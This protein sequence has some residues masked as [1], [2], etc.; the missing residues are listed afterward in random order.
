MDRRLF[1]MHIP[2]TAGTTFKAFLDQQFP[3]KN[4]APRGVFGKH[5]L[6]VQRS[7]FEHRLDELKAFSLFRGHYG[8]DICSAFAPDYTTLTIL[9]DP[10]KRVV[11]LYNDWRSKSEEHLK[12]AKDS[13]KSLAILAKNLSFQDFF[14]AEHPLIPLFFHN[15][16]ARPLAH[17]FRSDLEEE[18]LYNL[19]IANLNT[20]DYVGVTKTFDLFL[21]LLCKQFGWHYSPQFQALN[22]ARYC[23]RVEDL[24][25]TTLATI[26]AKN[27]VDLALYHRAQERALMTANQVAKD[28]TG[29]KTY[30]DFRGRSLITI[31][32]ADPLPGTGWHA[33]AG[34]E[35]DRLW[36]WTGPSL[37]TTL[38]LC[39]DPKRYTLSLRV[40]FV[41]DI[42][43]LHHSR[44][45]VNGAPVSTEIHTLAEDFFIKGT[46]P[47]VLI[48][49]NIP[50]QLTLSVPRTLA[51][52]DVDPTL[53]DARQKGLA[54]QEITLSSG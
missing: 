35:G 39:L 11:S 37:E 15:G 33:R 13:E 18:K 26:A 25:K 28:A 36:R 5:A 32:M 54:I 46:I 31:T 53:A 49:S 50:I 42:E 43:I 20:I 22:T 40:I 51:P 30:L 8:Y 12:K 2:K 6:D 23:L 17:S 21:W 4:I 10:F 1:F 52:T 3:L 19:A 41:A 27:R 47:R 29:P 24:N 38:F 7:D 9:R 14:Q 45:S 44:I 34:V 16:Q 48:S